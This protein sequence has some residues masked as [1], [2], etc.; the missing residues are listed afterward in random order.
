MK[1][2]NNEAFKR[3]LIEDIGRETAWL[4]LMFPMDPE[5]SES[6]ELYL[7]N[8]FEMV[9]YL[10]VQPGGRDCMVTVEVFRDRALLVS[11]VIL[12]RWS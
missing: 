7:G 4:L 1:C 2:F 10:V 9:G 8:E 12:R 3:P 5:L 11:R 6:V